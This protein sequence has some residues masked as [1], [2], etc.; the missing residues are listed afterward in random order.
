MVEAE[1]WQW[2]DTS[3]ARCYGNSN[4]WR[5]DRWTRTAGHYRGKQSVSRDRT[6][7]L[8]MRLAAMYGKHWLDM[9]HGI[10]M[11]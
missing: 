2:R 3:E 7:V 6:D 11:T 4:F 10:P 1:Q 9:W 8:F 5:L